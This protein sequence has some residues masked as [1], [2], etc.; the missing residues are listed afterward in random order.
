MNK[1]RII[2]IAIFFV[3]SLLT[4]VYAAVKVGGS[5]SKAGIKTTVLNKTYTCIKSGKKL[6]WDK[7]RNT[8]SFN[9]ESFK[10]DWSS[11]RSTDSGY[12][13]DYFG[14]NQHDLDLEGKLQK[15][16]LAYSSHTRSGGIYR[17]A[18]YE[19]GKLRPST[20]LSTNISDLPINQCQISDPPNINNV[21]GFPNL[22]D[23]GF[24]EYLNSIKVPGPKMQ[25]Q[26]IPIFTPDSAT[27]SNSPSEDYDV[28]FNF[29]QT[30]AEYSSDGDSKIIFKVPPTYLQFSKNLASYNL[31]HSNNH[32]N[33][34]NIRF[35]TD[36]IAEIDGKIDF[37]GTDIVLIVSPAGTQH[38]VFQ[39]SV[40]KNFSTNEGKINSGMTATPFTLTGLGE[41]DDAKSRHSNFVV[42]YW[43]LHEMYHA[44]FGLLDHHGPREDRDRYGLGEWTL[45]S[46]NGGD[47]S[48]WEKWILGFITDSQVHCLNTSQ[49][50][51]RWIA[52]SSVKTKEKKLVVIP[53]S[54]TKGII[55]ESIR[56]AGLYYK[57]PK[58]SNGVLIYVVD[59]DL[60]DPGLELKL[61]LPSN[62]NPDQP[63]SW[64][65][66]ATL[67]EGEFVVSNGH[68][69][70]IVESGNFG[71]VVKVEKVS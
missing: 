57:I 64:L 29:I 10:R 8:N 58:A 41:L 17:I 40:I 52:P 39:Q 59:L 71:D 5:C 32:D 50:Q 36:L 48:A 27:P 55:I 35:A 7:G 45:M 49:T 68:K 24:K 34:E 33:P 51:V 16:H 43:W 2:F 14:W 26:V 21:R 30:W 65:S 60:R 63:P 62:R 66:Q 19:L 23:S 18:K 61:V 38:K 42:P 37:T 46:G 70:T 47:L 3:S 4:P 67:R 1:K 54:Q 44:G 20:V 11:I 12:L 15:I 69:I 25:V 6:I 53:L 13:N 56:P 9:S 22:R 31:K 28:Y